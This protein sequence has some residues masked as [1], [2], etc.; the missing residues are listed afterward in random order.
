MR[1]TSTSSPTAC[2]CSSSPGRSTD[3]DGT[4]GT[5]GVGDLNLFRQ[6]FLLNPTARETDYNCDGVTDVLDFNIFRVDF[7]AMAVGTYCP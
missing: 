6:N 7:L 2:P 5:C 4:D 3:L 1:T